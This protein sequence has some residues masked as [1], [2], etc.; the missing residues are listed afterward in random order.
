MNQILS[1]APQAAAPNLW[2]GAGEDRLVERIGRPIRPDSR[3]SFAK[4][5]EKTDER[6]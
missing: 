1:A 2:P 5:F 3:R 6:S 4:V